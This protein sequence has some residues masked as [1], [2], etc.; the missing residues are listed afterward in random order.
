MKGAMM[1]FCRVQS[2]LILLIALCSADTG[3]A[4]DSFSPSGG[5]CNTTFDPN[6]VPPSARQVHLPVACAPS[7]A[8][9][10]SEAGPHDVLEFEL[11]ADFDTINDVNIGLANKEEAQSSGTLRYSDPD[12]GVLVEIPITLKARGKSRFS[13]CAYRPLTIVFPTHQTGNIFEGVSKKLKVV[14]HC[15]NHPTDPWLLGGTP[16][17]QRRHLLAEY[18]FYQ[19]LEALGSTALSTRLARITYRNQD[20]SAIT[21]EFAFLREREDDACKRCGFLDEV[22]AQ[23]PLTPEETTVFQAHLYNKFVY[24]ND[25][26]LEVGHN[27]RVCLDASNQHYFIPYDW[28]LTGVV[29][30]EYRF[31]GPHYSDNVITFWDWLNGWVDQDKAKIQAL[32]LVDHD[33]E[34]WGILNNTLMDDEGEALMQGWYSLYMC[35]LRCYLGIGGSIDIIEP[36]AALPSPIQPEDGSGRL[37]I[38]LDYRPLSAVPTKDD[39]EVLIGGAA[40]SVLSGS[41]V[42]SQYWLVVQTPAGVPGMASLLVRCRLC[43]IPVEDSEMGAVA[44]GSLGNSDT[45]LVIDTSGSMNDDRKLESAKNAAALFV[46][47]MRDGERIGVVE[48]AGR[49]PGG[50]GRSEDVA[51]IDSAM[52]RRA[53]VEDDIRD[54]T[55]NFSTPLGTGLLHGLEELDSIPSADRNQVRTIILLSDGKENVANFWAAPPDWYHSPPRAPNTPVI[56]T[57]NA[58]ANRAVKIHTISLGPDANPDLMEAISSGRGRYLHADLITA[59]S[60]ARLKL[61]GLPFFPSVAHADTADGISQMELPLRLSNVYEHLHNETTLQQRLAQRVHLT[62]S[63]ATKPSKTRGNDGSFS[64]GSADEMDLYIEEGLSYATISISWTDPVVKNFFIRPPP[65]QKSASIG[66]TQTNTNAVFRIDKPKSGKWILGSQYQSKGE[67]LFITL[68]GRSTESGILRAVEP[69]GKL[70]PGDTI[71]VVLALVGDKPILNATVT[72]TIRSAANGIEKI[73]LYDNGEGNDLQAGDG[74]YSGYATRTKKG[75]IFKF[76]TRATWKGAD[77]QQHSRIFPLSVSIPELDSDGDGI[78][79]EDETRFGLNPRSPKD[80][81]RDHDKDGLP[82]WKEIQIGTDPFN[83]DTDGGGAAD[84]PEVSLGSDPEYP[85][86]DYLINIDSD[87]DTMPDSWEIAFSLDPNDPADAGKDNDKD[88]LPNAAEFKHGTSPINPD[89]DGDK[90]PDGKDV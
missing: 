9:L 50:Y 54:L 36:S 23:P 73:Q 26:I 51:P 38:R 87:G 5:T 29:H 12:T 70:Q 20:G 69:E 37:L 76:E 79:D 72:A 71:P 18:Y 8:P 6:S 58:T 1:N 31:N 90:I 55:A 11:Q 39:F 63:G 61:P 49:E 88:G 53:A 14:T 33:E 35:A 10:F 80:A 13:H 59:G 78:S 52:G 89:T 32:H 22:N 45:V 40:A 85:E 67:A 30:P 2:I 25:Y 84:G 44:F 56:D 60:G 46:N 74:F 43:A 28:D 82:T 77:R 81:G 15:G 3:M 41:Q 48:Y 4:Q 19:V 66:V 65:G 7:S 21:T 62:G 47:T 42:G 57:F 75:G 27:T 68:S 24:N 34:M 64:G 86:D 17:E 16:E 83:P